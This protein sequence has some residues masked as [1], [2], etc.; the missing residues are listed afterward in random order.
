MFDFAPN[1]P[2]FIMIIVMMAAMVLWH[3]NGDRR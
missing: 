3:A 1:Q 2:P